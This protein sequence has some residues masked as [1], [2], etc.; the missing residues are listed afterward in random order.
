MQKVR[1]VIACSSQHMLADI[2]ENTIKESGF[3]DMV[4][5]VN[6]TMALD[7]V[8]ARTKADVLIL[9]LES[10]EFVRVCAQVMGQIANILVIGLVDDGRRLAVVLDNTGSSDIPNIIRTL[11]GEE[12]LQ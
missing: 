11:L 6:D 12:L 5:R 7:A 1:C 4:E 10:H 8:V 3:I 9:G 2:V